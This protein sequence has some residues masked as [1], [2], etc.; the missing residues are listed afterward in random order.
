MAQSREQKPR[1]NA[2]QE[3]E[4]Y[5]FFHAHVLTPGPRSLLGIKVIV[6]PKQTF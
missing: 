2:K 4:A 3:R 6:R 5:A 1:V